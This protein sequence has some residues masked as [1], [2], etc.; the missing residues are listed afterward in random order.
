M[1]T[2]ASHIGRKTT[3]LLICCLGCLHLAA[4]A[5]CNLSSSGEDIVEND[6]KNDDNQPSQNTNKDTPAN[7][8]NDDPSNQNSAPHVKTDGPLFT[9]CS[10][11]GVSE[12][13]DLR[14]THCTGP[15][16]ASGQ[17]AEGDGLRL[18]AGVF[19][20]ISTY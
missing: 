3:V 14:L 16:D 20:A 7:V 13:E 2:A 8:N 4:V 18:E 15:G 6:D 1:A 11:G 17:V 19:E 9:L 5:G 10:A 12:G